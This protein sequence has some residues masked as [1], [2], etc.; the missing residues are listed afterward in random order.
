MHQEMADIAPG[1]LS[2][3][4]TQG[5]YSFGFQ[6]VEHPLHRR[7]AVNVVLINSVRGKSNDLLKPNRLLA[8][9]QRITVSLRS[10]AQDLRFFLHTSDDQD[11]YSRISEGAVVAS[12]HIYNFQVN[13]LVCTE[14]VV[15]ITSLVARHCWHQHLIAL[16]G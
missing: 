1:Y 11:I 9:L 4:A 3:F 12:A 16:D 13:C 5:R 7:I 8:P 2:S 6:T 14:L 15:L 10:S